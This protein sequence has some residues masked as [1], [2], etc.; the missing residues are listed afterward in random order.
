M[1]VRQPMPWLV[2]LAASVGLDCRCIEHPLYDA[3]VN[4]F[5]SF[6]LGGGNSQYRPF[7]RG[8]VPPDATLDVDLV[9]D[10][11]SSPPRL[12]MLVVDRV[13]EGEVDGELV[14]DDVPVGVFA[15][16][17]DDQL[18]LELSDETLARLA[19]GSQVHARVGD[20]TSEDV[21]VE[22]DVAEIT[23][24]LGDAPAGGAR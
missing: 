20:G 12:R 2:L 13:G 11:D 15:T 17:D 4:R 16:V 19:A 22:L 9:L 3:N 10:H 8:E 23:R 14:I 18:A 5:D 21:V 6:Y 24:V 1:N 7:R